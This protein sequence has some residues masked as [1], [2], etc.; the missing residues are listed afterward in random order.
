[1]LVN[2]GGV[3]QRSLFADTDLA[4]IRRILEINFFG[5]VALTRFILPHMI[6]NQS[7]HIIVTSSVAGKFGTKFRSGYAASKHALHGIFDCI[8]K[9]CMNTMC[10]LH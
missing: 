5:S 6:S 2:N 4:T 9:K 3:S 8:I 1:M 10:I 7:G